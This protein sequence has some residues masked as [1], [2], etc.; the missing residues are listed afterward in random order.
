MHDDFHTA[1]VIQFLLKLSA[2]K[3][4]FSDTQHF[5][6]FHVKKDTKILSIKTFS[7][8]LYTEI[9]PKFSYIHVTYEIQA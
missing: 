2:K 9:R 7:A 3:E 5:L 4:I 1:F 6:H 8:Q